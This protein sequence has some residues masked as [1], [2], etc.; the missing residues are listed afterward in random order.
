[1]HGTNINKFQEVDVSKHVKKGKCIFP[2]VYNKNTYDSCMKTEKGKI[3]ATEINSKTKNIKK[4][5]YCYIFKKPKKKATRK[6]RIKTKMEK[7]TYNQEFISILEEFQNIL[8]LKGEAF[9]A[10]AYKKA[11]NNIRLYEK[12]IYKIE[13]LKDISGIG[14]TIYAKLDEYVKTG[15]IKALDVYKANPIHKLL[16]VYGIGP[17]KAQQLV[18]EGIDSID[19]LREIKDTLTKAQQIGLKYYEDINEK[20]PREE[21]VLYDQIIGKIVKKISPTA[22]YEIVGSYRRGKAFSGDIDVI[23]SDETNHSDVFN[24]LIQKL[25]DENVLIEIL[26]K[27]KTKCLGVSKLDEFSKAR[28]IDFMTTP[29]EEYPFAIL[30]FTGSKDFNT[31]Q[32]QRALNLGYSLNEHGLYIMKNGVKGKKIKNDFPDEES[33][34]EF[35]HMKYIKPQKRVGYSFSHLLLPDSEIKNKKPHKLAIT[36][37]KPKNKTQGLKDEYFDK[38]KKQG[39]SYLK[40]LTKKQLEEMISIANQAYYIDGNPLLDDSSYDILREY[41]LSKYPDNTI[42]KD[43]H[44]M[45]KVEKNKVKL[46]YEMWSMDKIKPDTKALAKWKKSYKKNYVLSCKL[47]GVSGLYSTENKTQKLYTRGN[48]IM[49]QDV[50]Y[51]IP[52]LKLPKTENIVIRGEFI[53]KKK[54]FE[55]KYSDEFANPRNFVA[56]ILNKKTVDES[57]VK[58]LDFIAY[59]V[60]IPE[61]KPSDQMSFLIEENVI[62]V[63]YLIS[64]DI[65]NEKLS[66]LLL[67]W[68]D[69]YEYE[70]DG[71]ICTH[72]D[73]YKRI[74]GNP[75][76]AFA[77]KMVLGDQI[78]EAK[79]V[80]VIWT[81]SKDGYLKPRVQIEPINL[82]GVKIEYATGFNAKF[83][84]DNKIGVGAL[85]QLIRSGDVIPHITNIIEP[86]EEPLMPSIDYKWSE[87]GVDIILESKT[88]D[89]IVQGKIIG[90]FFK[91]IGVDGLGPGNVRK[92]MLAGFNTISKILSMTLDDFKSVDGFK[93]KMANKLYSGIQNKIK[94]ASLAKIMSATNI[95]GRGFGEKKIKLILKE[96][97]DIL[98]ASNKDSV[99][100]D[101][102]DKLTSVE[103]IGMKTAINFS[104]NI[105][106][107]LKWIDEANLGYKLNITQ[108]PQKSIDKTHILYGK[109]Y[110]FSGFRDKKLIEMLSDLGAIQK[111]SVSKNTFVVIVKDKYQDSTKIDKA[112]QLGI[113]IYTLDEFTEKF[114]SS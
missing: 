67:L 20:I 55:K 87:S 26:S 24:E 36:I 112:K 86:S 113:P 61:L 64:K 77:F 34:F 95:F 35:L 45:V 66:E 104:N 96:Y 1:M 21:I 59:E 68:R 28:R 60:I 72:D 30:Y 25:K 5:G 103:G 23:I 101:V 74:S 10:N 110:V 41:V 84:Y 49:G 3:C 8:Y 92:I 97:P 56:G 14:K 73:E 50:S 78:A 2:F 29:P 39:L 13:Q 98:S 32:R 51:M 105:P 69:S 17:K 108:S 114:L 15:S 31:F 19:K 111:S 91:D 62:P 75:K 27:G 4:Y 79:V 93:D 88:D 94:S 6:L 57:V 102:L 80:D 85:I 9:K 46:P 70:I 71:V 18:K 43:G 100:A 107:F 44:A 37:K 11:A 33:I 16:N 7:N 89:A 106:R 58:D 52:Y 83:I 81:A 22:K 12:P 38:F 82:G 76:H 63:K 65:T 54:V 109:S 47:D 90:K 99:S 42:A 53:I 40:T 48:G